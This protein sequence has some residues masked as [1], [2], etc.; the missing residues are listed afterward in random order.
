VTRLRRWT[1]VGVLAA[2]LLLTG[3]V[4]TSGADSAGAQDYEFG[5]LTTG[6]DGLLPV[7]DR[8]PAP[9]LVGQTLQGDPLDT[10]AMRGQVVVLNFWADWCAPCRAEAPF[11]NAVATSTKDRGV[12]FVGVNVKNDRSSA[13]AFERVSG[14]PY[15][16]LY[17]QPGALLLRFRKVVPQTPPST[18]LI[19]RQG[20]LAGIF[21]AGVTEGELSGPVLALAAE[22]A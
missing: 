17:D 6:S 7:G 9:P 13:L 4:G 22:P 16:S 15:P 10:G 3:C 1:L 14:T 11:L 12:A 2:P 21:Y 5:R 18:M 8:R 19:D 20:R